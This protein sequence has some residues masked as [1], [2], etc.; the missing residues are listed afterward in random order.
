MGT[1]AGIARCPVRPRLSHLLDG[2]VLVDLLLTRWA[3]QR[4]AFS[5]IR[6]INCKAALRL[7]AHP[8]LRLK[9]DSALCIRSPEVCARTCS[10]QDNDDLVL[11]TAAEVVLN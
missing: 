3:N 7:E 4:T 1:V 8:S 5:I 2:L 6:S 11:E 9:C 10:F